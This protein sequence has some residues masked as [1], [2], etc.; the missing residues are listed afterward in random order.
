M[1]EGVSSA[2]SPSP[3]LSQSSPVVLIVKTLYPNLTRP[4][5]GDRSPC[6]PLR[7]PRRVRS[8]AHRTR[9][10]PR[11]LQDSFELPSSFHTNPLITCSTQTTQTRQF[12]DGAPN[13]CPRPHGPPRPAVSTRPQQRQPGPPASPAVSTRITFSGTPSEV[14]PRG[15]GSP[16]QEPS[17]IHTDPEPRSGPHRLPVPL[18]RLLP[19]TQSRDMSPESPAGRL[20]QLRFSCRWGGAWRGLQPALA[21]LTPGP[22]LRRRPSWFSTGGADS[23]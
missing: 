7:I 10:L 13:P 12:P 23:S 18:P 16:P 21:R 11:T 5:L 15:R 14:Q 6:T 8:P 1:L 20:R 2:S 4:G 3:L 22:G 19:P 17:R 9:L